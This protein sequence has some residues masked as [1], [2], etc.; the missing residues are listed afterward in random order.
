A[1]TGAQLKVTQEPSTDLANMPPQPLHS[2]MR[3]N[4]S[5]PLNHRIKLTGTA[6]LRQHNGNLYLA[7]EEAGILVRS[8]QP[9][10]VR[11]G[12]QVE[13][14]GF[15]PAHALPLVLE[16][17]IVR[18]TGQGNVP[19]PK[20]ITVDE[21][22]KGSCDARLVRLS[23]FLVSH[24]AVRGDHVLTMSAGRRQFRAVLEH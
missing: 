17:A 19:T 2:L 13:A 11:A 4:A 12:A 8:A 7:D 14:A 6:V 9:H 15:L 18:S 24:N 20:E 23:A 21:A 16:D 22:A 1:Q 10:D 3:F 5:H